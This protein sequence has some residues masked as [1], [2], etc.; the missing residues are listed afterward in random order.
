MNEGT[1]FLDKLDAWLLQQPEWL[2]I[3]GLPKNQ[4][5]EAARLV[6]RHLTSAPTAKGKTMNRTAK[7]KLIHDFKRDE[8]SPKLRQLKGKRAR[9]EAKQRR[10]AAR[11]GRMSEERAYELALKEEFERMQRLVNTTSTVEEEAYLENLRRGEEVIGL[12]DGT[13]G[14]SVPGL[15]PDVS[16]RDALIGSEVEIAFIEDDRIAEAMPLD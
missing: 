15:T 4:R 11:Y 9:V 12:T 8:V 16:L 6:A 7:R 14:Q 13:L 5:K 10:D 3:L 2:V 1:S